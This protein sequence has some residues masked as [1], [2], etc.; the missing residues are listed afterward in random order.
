MLRRSKAPLLLTCLLLGVY[1][2][3][4][5]PKPIDA[6]GQALLAVADTAVLHGRLD[7]NVIGY[8]EWLLTPD[9]RMGNLGVD[10]ALYAK[11]GP[12]PSFALMPLVA[13]A[14]FLP[15]LPNQATAMLFN[16]LITTAT[17]L[18]L[19]TLARWL[20]YD[21][22]TALVLGLIFGCATFAATYVKTLF[23]EPLAGLLLLLAV[24][25]AYRWRLAFSHQLSALSTFNSVLSPQSSVLLTP[26]SLLIT[27]TLLALLIGVNTVY[28]VFVPVV[29]V[30]IFWGQNIRWLEIAKFFVP[31]ALGLALLG[32]YNWVRF[33]TPL[34]SGY[35]FAEGE[36]FN[37]PLLIG[38]YGLF[39]S[40]YRGLFWYNPILI[41]AIPGW[42]MLRQ[43][44]TRLAW[45]A[46]ALIVLQA[47]AFASWWS[48]HG[49]IVWGPRFL[50]PAL[51]LATLALA[52]IIKAVRKQRFLFV[53]LGVFAVLS[54]GV[55]VLGSLY[56]YLTYDGYLRIHYWP[57]LATANEMLRNSRVMFD[58]TLSPITGHLALLKAG[59]RTEP[60]WM[61]NGI[62]VIHLIAAL[63]L[64]GIGIFATFW[65]RVDSKRAW[66]VGSLAIFISLNVVAMRQNSDTV[67]ELE[68]T[69]QPPGIVV[70]VT[71]HFD[72]ALMD[73]DNGVRIIA[74]NAPTSPDDA[75]AQTMWDYALH[76]DKTFWYLTWYG[77][78]DPANWQE[79]QLWQTAYF[80]IE[81]TIANHRALRFDLTP[82]IEPNQSSG[83][84]FGKIQLDSYTFSTVDDGVRI[85]LQWSANQPLSENVSW[86][87]HLVNSV[88]EIVAQQD[89]QPQGGYA[90]T[91]SWTE[92]VTD[93]LFFPLPPNRDMSGWQVRI[94][95]V[96]PTSGE[97]LAVF[98][99]N[100]APIADGFILIPLKIDTP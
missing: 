61:A 75:L 63:A 56:N 66:V 74:M 93:R 64:I 50:L 68:Q 79:R 98:D 100:G 83:W 27:G 78:A 71:T 84:R 11:K 81:R 94:G 28:V 23:G 88:G 69:L 95:W 57:D 80:V 15:W 30:Y 59:W 18:A 55:Q 14:H 19:Y 67:R 92:S 49:G 46:L 1:L 13:L 5:V 37:N 4:Y 33:G 62:D 96:D 31:I 41:L 7:M 48:W 6:D 12:T 35:H 53:I 25:F 89:R 8:T 32:L 86:F 29:A 17:A 36:G 82:P 44:I 99:P 2:L 73:V 22:W 16:A 38:L 90:P 40:P 34:A 21:E 77:V 3:I 47:L 70:T 39:F 76:Q 52:P 43:Q 26:Y 54:L 10:G 51:P 97:R 42:L 72:T 65:R 91:S 58:P 20:D 9:G 85:S 87:V 24:M 60:A 45:L